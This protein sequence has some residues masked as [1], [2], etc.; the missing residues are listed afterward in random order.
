GI[1]APTPPTPRRAGG[2]GPRD[3]ERGPPEPAPAGEGVDPGVVVPAALLG[4]D[5]LGHVAHVGQRALVEVG[6]VVGDDDDI[7]A[8][9]A[10]D[11]RGDPRLD[12]VL[13]DPLDLDLDAGLLGE[14]RRL[15]VEEDVGRLHVVG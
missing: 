8:A 6:V 2:D 9:A 13:V 7:G 10:L 5:R 1:P 12:V 3:E 11:G 15:L 4:A 14:L